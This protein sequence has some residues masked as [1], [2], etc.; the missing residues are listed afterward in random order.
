MTR[1]FHSPD[2][3]IPDINMVDMMLIKEGLDI[4]SVDLWKSLY[5]TIDELLELKHKDM[6]GSSIPRNKKR[7]ENSDAKNE[8]MLV[9]RKNLLQKLERIVALKNLTERE[10]DDLNFTNTVHSMIYNT[11]IELNDKYKLSNEELLETELF[12]ILYLCKNV[13]L[14]EIEMR[15]ELKYE[16][17]KIRKEEITRFEQSR[18]TKNAI[19]T[20][21]VGSFILFSLLIIRTS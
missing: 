4:R 16:I 21:L 15:N 6:Q 10:T 7:L 9:E 19:I 5:S 14:L 11:V 2:E 8:G 1:S 12:A 17:P 18:R 3:Q 13:D 20:T